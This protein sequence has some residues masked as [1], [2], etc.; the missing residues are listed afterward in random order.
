MNNKKSQKSQGQQYKAGKP[1]TKKKMLALELRPIESQ[2][3]MVEHLVVRESPLLCWLNIIKYAL[4][5]LGLVFTVFMVAF[6]YRVDG[7]FEIVIHDVA[8]KST[9]LIVVVSVVI[10]ALCCTIAGILHLVVKK[11]SSKN[12]AER[13]GEKILF[14]TDNKEMTYSYHAAGAPSNKKTKVRIPLTKGQVVAYNP[15]TRQLSFF[16]MG[17]DA[18]Q[19]DIDVDEVFGTL[20]CENAKIKCDNYIIYDY[21]RPSLYEALRDRKVKLIGGEQSE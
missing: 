11:K 13:S 19:E 3:A 14:S 9:V 10:I 7:L 12:I 1:D 6:G 4:P 20:A 17:K 5:I 21:F 2:K 16:L 8:K 18:P 15:A